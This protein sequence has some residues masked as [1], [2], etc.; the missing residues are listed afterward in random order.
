LLNVRV[1]PQL[2]ET[3]IDAG[4]VDAC[5]RDTTDTVCEPFQA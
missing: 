1:A 4:D 2:I 3:G 5:P